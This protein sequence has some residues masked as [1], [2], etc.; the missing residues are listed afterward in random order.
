MVGLR[1]AGDFQMNKIH[2]VDRL[3]LK[4]RVPII[5]GAALCFPVFMLSYGYALRWLITTAPIWIS[6]P[7]VISHLVVFLGVASLIDIRE[8]LPRS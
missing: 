8:G 2:P 4:L 7:S 3:M 6:A 1:F 5:I